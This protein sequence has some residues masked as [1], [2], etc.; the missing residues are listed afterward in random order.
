MNP[1]KGLKTLQKQGENENPRTLGF[2]FFFL[3]NAGIK[4]RITGLRTAE[5]GPVVNT[6]GH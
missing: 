1:V 3:S 5:Y 4:M 6:N 2:Q